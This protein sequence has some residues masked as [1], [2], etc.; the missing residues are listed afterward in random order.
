M[1][2]KPDDVRRKYQVRDDNP[3]AR[4]VDSVFGKEDPERE[5]ER[6]ENKRNRGHYRDRGRPQS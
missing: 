6:E 3:I 4:V 1:N 5:R 2:P